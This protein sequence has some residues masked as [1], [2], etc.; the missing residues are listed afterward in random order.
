MIALLQRV[1]EASVTVD[2]ATVARIGTGLLV[3]VGV[4]RGDTGAQAR[5]LAERLLGYRV[6]PDGDGRMNLGIRETG[7]ALLLVPQFTLAA[8]T[9]KGMRP[10][11]GAAADPDTGAARFED[12]V[13]HARA[14]GVA[15]ETGVFGAHMRVHLVNDG[16]VTFRLRVPPPP[17]D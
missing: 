4:E 17:A 8:D 10:G 16:P 13:S 3:L 1:T 7:G 11:F 9:D 15:V 2:D 12:L 14:G 6:F 5:R